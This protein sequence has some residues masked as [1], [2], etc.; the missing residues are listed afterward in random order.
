[1]CHI[2]S[3]CHQSRIVVRSIHCCGGL[4]ACKM[5]HHG[6]RDVC[7]DSLRSYPFLRSQVDYCVVIHELPSLVSSRQRSALTH[8]SCLSPCLLP[9]YICLPELALCTPLLEKMWSA[10][11]VFTCR[12]YVLALQPDLLL[13]SSV[14]YVTYHNVSGLCLKSMHFLT[15]HHV[16]LLKHSRV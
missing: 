2:T 3:I 16:H 15:L 11:H 14:L 9:T 1:M 7:L 8:V 4:H 5:P 6:A 12:F 13:I 10:R